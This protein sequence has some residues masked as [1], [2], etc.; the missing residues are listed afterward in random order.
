[1]NNNS[2]R[3]GYPDT[4]K[5]SVLKLRDTF[6]EIIKNANKELI[7]KGADP[8]LLPSPF[9]VSFIIKYSKEMKTDTPMELSSGTDGP[10]GHEA[11]SAECQTGL[12]IIDEVSIPAYNMTFPRSSLIDIFDGVPCC[13]SYYNINCFDLVQVA[14]ARRA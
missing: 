11:R 12:Y 1:M 2:Y 6:H 5:V 7:E 9:I 4:V 8:Q 13:N 14:T 10:K 3:S